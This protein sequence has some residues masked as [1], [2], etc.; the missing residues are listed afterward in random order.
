MQYAQRVLI[1]RSIE[2]DKLNFVQRGQ[3]DT[4]GPE[5]TRQDTLPL[6]Q[7]GRVPS[8][9]VSSSNIPLDATDANPLLPIYY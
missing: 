5:R 7:G 3:K 4:P 1:A 6:G 2:S 9:E 8:E